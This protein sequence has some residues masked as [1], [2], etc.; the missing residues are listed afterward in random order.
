MFCFQQSLMAT[1]KLNFEVVAANDTVISGQNNVHVKIRFSA[2]D[3]SLHHPNIIVNK[4]RKIKKV[5][6]SGSLTYVNIA[7]ME[8]SFYIPQKIF[9]RKNYVVK[10]DASL[11][12]WES[13]VRKRHVFRLDVDKLHKEILMNYTIKK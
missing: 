8:H 10:I 5:Y 6:E 3:W 11:F 9:K 4:K 2:D 1:E 12:N 13:A 7:L